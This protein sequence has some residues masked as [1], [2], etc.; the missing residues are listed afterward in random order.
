MV[1]KDYLSALLNK[2]KTVDEEQSLGGFWADT[3]KTQEMLIKA[4][5]DM[6]KT[7]VLLSQ[8]EGFKDICQ[9]IAVFIENPRA[10]KLLIRK[11][12]LQQAINLSLDEMLLLYELSR[13]FYDKSQFEEAAGIANLLCLL[14]RRISS[15]WRMV[16]CCQLGLNNKGAALAPFLQASMTNSLAIENH[17]SALNCLIELG[18]TQEALNYYNTAKEVLTDGGQENDILQLDAIINKM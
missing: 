6:Q 15:F 11:G 18:F 8:E 5:M 7:F 3:E 9:K 10:T 1:E 12:T 16:G 2:L 4:V 13:K 14:N 17:I